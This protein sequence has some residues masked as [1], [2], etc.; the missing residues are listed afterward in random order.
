[1]KNSFL[2]LSLLLHLAG[3][4]TLADAR[5]ARGSGITV[6]YFAS[7]EELWRL[8]PRVANDL[9]L[10]VAGSFEKDGIL[11]AER[12]LSA[13]SF[14]ERVAVFLDRVDEKK[15]RMEVVAKKVFLFQLSVGRFE[16]RLHERMVEL[17][18]EGRRVTPLTSTPRNGI[19]DMN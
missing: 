5:A 15:T 6:N 11:L 9:D 7:F 13:F 10:S 1:M 17:V 4:N 2:L 16:A 14:G 18:R 12:G 19:G 3:C 8:L